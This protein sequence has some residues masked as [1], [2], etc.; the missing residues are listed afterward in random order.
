LSILIKEINEVNKALQSHHLDVNELKTKLVELLQ[1]LSKLLLVPEKI[2]SKTL[3]LL[4]IDWED[5]VT[6]MDYFM[7]AQAFINYLSERVDYRLSDLKVLNEDESF[8]HIFYPFIAHILK[9]F[10]ENSPLRNE[11]IQLIDFVELR[12]PSH[13]IEKSIMRFN[14]IFQIFP[15]EKSPEIAK[16]IIKLTNM[17]LTREMK[18]SMSSSLYLWD[19]VRN[20]TDFTYLSAIF[21]AAHSLPTSSAPVEQAFSSLKLIKSNL[22]NRLQENTLQS[23]MM[24]SEKFKSNSHENRITVSNE[25]IE[26]FNRAQQDLCFR[27]SKKIGKSI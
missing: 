9:Y 15:K 3:E 11:V 12:S 4:D 14:D 25:M 5:E 24:I 6:Q 27:K 26:Y 7:D 20:T 19:L 16:E 2:P 13:I 8:K 10:C 18:M 23:L 21:L 1:W 17:D 22:R